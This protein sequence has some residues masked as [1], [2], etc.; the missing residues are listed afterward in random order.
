MFAYYP[1]SLLSDVH[2]S[3]AQSEYVAYENSF[4]SVDIVYDGTPESITI[5]YSVNV[6]S[7]TAIGTVK[8]VFESASFKKLTFYR[9]C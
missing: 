9:W 1:N 3:F 2:V 7:L 8:L 5:T 4:A 6:T